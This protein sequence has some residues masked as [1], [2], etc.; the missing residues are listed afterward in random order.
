MGAGLDSLRHL[1]KPGH[2]PLHCLYPV[3]V[4]HQRGPLPGCN[5]APDV[6]QEKKIEETC[7]DHDLLRLD[8]GRDH[9]LSSYVWLVSIYDLLLIFGI[10]YLFLLD[11]K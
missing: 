9:H 1:D 6:L 7:S 5:Q 8:L 4:C 3:P 10:L 11:K 2:S